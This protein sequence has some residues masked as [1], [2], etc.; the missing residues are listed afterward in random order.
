MK[1]FA[2][3][4]LA[5]TLTLSLAAPAL[6]AE[7]PVLISSKLPTITVNGAVLDTSKLPKADGIPLR[8]F[9]EADGGSATWYAEENSSN[10]YT[11]DGSVSVNFTTGVAT[12]GSKEFTKG[13]EAIEGVTFVSAEIVGA[14]SGVTVKQENGNYTI[15]TAASDPLVK[16]AKN[17]MET[18][19]MAK[20]MKQDAAS[21]E[22][23]FNIK[24]ENFESIVAYMPMMIS[25]DTVIVG[26]AAPGKMKE[27]KAD[28]QGRLDATIQSFE[29]YLP[30]PLEMAKKGK[31]VE[32]NGYVML[33][34]SP[35]TATAIDLFNT[36]VKGL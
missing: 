15:T 29:Q 8:A 10:F 20:G 5:A 7:Q 28:L 24:Q 33:I 2:S 21:L 26:K 25:A 1:K 14:I 27:A 23:Y 13:V 6:A 9:V 35:D 34:I 4:A 22:Q 30:G 16:L 18:T 12:V 11:E 31:I 32:K 36:A 3:L 17:I 19:E